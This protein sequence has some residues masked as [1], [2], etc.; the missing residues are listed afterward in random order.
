MRRVRPGT[1]SRG[2]DAGCPARPG[3]RS[4]HWTSVAA[5]RARS[6]GQ[7]EARATAPPVARHAQ[8]LRASE[9][10]LPEV[11]RGLEQLA[12]DHP[13]LLTSRY[14]ADHAEIRYWEEARD[15]H[16]AAAV[17]LRLWGEHRLDAPSC[18]PGR[19]SA[20]RSS[21]AP[22]TTSASPRAT[23]RRPAVTRRRPPVL[24][25]PGTVLG[26]RWNAAMDGRVPGLGAHY[27]RPCMTSLSPY[28]A[29]SPVAQAAYRARAAA[30]DLAPLPRAA[31]DDALLA[32]A[33][34]LEV[35]TSEIV[36]ANAE[37]VAKAREAGTSEAIIDRLTLT[38]ERVARHR[39]RRARRRRPA[40]PGRRGGARLHPA[41]RHRPAPGPRPARRRR[42]HLRG[43]AQRHRGRRRAL[44]EVR[45][46]GPAA[47][48]LLR[49][50]L[51]HRPGTRP[52]RRR[53]RRRPARRR[54]A[55]RPRREPRL[56]R[57]S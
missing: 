41:Q 38:P 36:E 1:A 11:R 14:A 39:R 30:A 43:P 46:R 54:G 21:T 42:H 3:R 31:K 8:R 49:L 19:S 56:R 13:F 57:A 4:A 25:R 24:S 53:R 7:Q 26:S 44:P 52:A 6:P 48:L 51:Q 9:A 47:R 29:M 37:D 5:G 32:I 16:D 23:A 22:P 45:Q 10:P 34:A 20:W 55:A 50:R 12:H 27:G 2:D 35:R 33:D 40:R 18:R 28:A 17:A 15:L